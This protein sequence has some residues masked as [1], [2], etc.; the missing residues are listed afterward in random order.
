MMT[1]SIAKKMISPIAHAGMQTSLPD[2]GPD[3]IERWSAMM[4]NDVPYGFVWEDM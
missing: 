1:M 4:P 2:H 3:L